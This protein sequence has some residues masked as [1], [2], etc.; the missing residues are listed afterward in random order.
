MRGV[1][2]RKPLGT[3]TRGNNSPRQIKYLPPNK[4]QIIPT[5]RVNPC[6][7]APRWYQSVSLPVT[8]LSAYFIAG[9]ADVRVGGGSSPRCSRSGD[10]SIRGCK[11]LIRGDD[12]S[13]ASPGKVFGSLERRG[14][15]VGGG[16]L[17]PVATG[18]RE[19]PLRPCLSSASSLGP[20][21]SSQAQAGR[22]TGQTP[23]PTLLDLGAGGS[24]DTGCC[25][26]HVGIAQS[27][28][29]HGWYLSICRTQMPRSPRPLPQA[30]GGPRL[31]PN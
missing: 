6:S 20:A 14:G 11:G 26:P 29:H 4:T 16:G 31:P 12:W 18:S 23:S 9:R 30:Q 28:S 15:P 25:C 3:N 1:S 10:T 5:P 7:Q 22:G 21:A 8:H 2:H 19:G 27:T 13:R 24:L 17:G